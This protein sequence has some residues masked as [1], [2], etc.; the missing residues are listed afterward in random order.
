M[1]DVVEYLAGLLADGYLWIDRDRHDYQYRIYDRWREF[2]VLV[3]KL[4]GGLGYE[5]HIY[6]RGGGRWYE[7]VVY[8]KSF[9]SSIAEVWERLLGSPTV[10]FARGLADAEAS[11]IRGNPNRVK[12][13]NRDERVASAFAKVLAQNNI[14]HR[15]YTERRASGLDHVVVITGVENIARFAYT[16]GFLHPEKRRRLLNFWGVESPP[17]FGITLS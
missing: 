9:V 14:P 16:V 17:F 7:L 4:I 11:V 1:E 12:F 10:A 3:A 8:S 5:A 6:A 15:V 2:L 13:T